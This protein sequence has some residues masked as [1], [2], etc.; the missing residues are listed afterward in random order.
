MVLER[1]AVMELSAIGLDR[2]PLARRWLGESV[3]IQRLPRTGGRIVDPDCRI[4]HARPG[5]IDASKPPWLSAGFARVMAY[6][7]NVLAAAAVVFVGYI[8]ANFLYRETAARGAGTV[9][10]ARLVRGAILTVAGFMACSSSASPP[11]L[12][13]PRSRSRCRR[14]RS[15]ACWRSAWETASWPDGSRATGTSGRGR[16]SGSPPI[17][18]V[19]RWTGHRRRGAPT[20]R[21]S[22]HPAPAPAVEQPPLLRGPRGPAV[23][24][25]SRSSDCRPD[26]FVTD[27]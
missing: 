2:R 16:A 7:P 9:V 12:S 5:A 22:R 25:R 21:P 13:P 26:E 15:R 11:R 19:R 18:H 17:R 1:V 8:A 3:A 24:E 10:W 23:P 20:I 14:W 6:L 27:S 4:D